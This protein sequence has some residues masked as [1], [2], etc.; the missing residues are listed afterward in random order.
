MLLSVD[1]FSYVLKYLAWANSSL[2]LLTY[3]LNW[4]KFSAVD[5]FIPA[6]VFKNFALLANI[7]V[8][9]VSPRYC[10]LERTLA[11]NFVIELPPSESLR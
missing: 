1:V 7:R 2:S 9:R 6:L 8:E 4:S 10:L 11:S 5:S 3:C